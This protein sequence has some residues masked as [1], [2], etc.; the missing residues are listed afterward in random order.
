[1]KKFLSFFQCLALSLSVGVLSS[2][3]HEDDKSA[4]LRDVTADTLAY[5]GAV[6]KEW[7]RLAD[8]HRDVTGESLGL[9]QQ[10]TVYA[11]SNKESDS[12]PVTQ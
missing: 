9:P 8:L 4:D 11:Q 2:L 12:T 3:A 6:D 5:Q 10:P 1:M 7:S